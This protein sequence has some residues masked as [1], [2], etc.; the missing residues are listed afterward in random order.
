MLPPPISVSPERSRDPA[1]EYKRVTVAGVVKS[2]SSERPGLVTLEIGSGSRT[3]WAT[4]PAS[5]AVID[6]QWIDAEVRASGVLDEALDGSA[7]GADSRLWMDVANSLEIVHPATPL[8]ALPPAAIRTLLAV[9]PAKLPQHRVRVRGVPYMP[10]LGGIG[11]LD[12]RGQIQVRMVQ[13]DLDPNT[14]VLDVA[15]FLTWEQGHA[16]LDHAVPIL[17]PVV[18]EPDLAPVPGTLTTA[19]QVHSLSLIEAQRAYAVKL[20]AVVTF[21][22]PADHVLFVQDQSDGIFVQ[23]SVKEKAP[24][25]AGDL[26]E[27]TGVTSADFAPNIDKARVKIIGHPGLPAAKKGSYE[28]AGWGR[29]DCHWLELGGVVQG[30]A[31]GP[32]DALVTIASGRNM[33]KAHVLATPESLAHLVD[34]EVKVRG[35]LG[36]LFNN[37]HQLLGIQMF[38]P[39]A[40]FI[41]VTETPAADPFSVAPTSIADLLRFSKARDMGHRVRVRGTVTYPSQTGPTWVRDATGGVKIHDHGAEELATGDLVDVVGYSD[42]AGFGPALHG[43]RVKRLQSGKPPAPVRVTAQEAMKAGLD[44]QLVQIEGKLLDR[45]QQPGE[46]VLAVEAGDVIFNASLLGG[47]AALRLESGTRLRLTGICSV[48]TELSHDLILPR[49][50]RLLLRS[51]EDIVIVGRPPL[52]TVDR[53]LPILGG[54]ALL[55]LAALAWVGLLRRRVRTQ[56]FALRAQT[57]QLKAAHEKTIDALRKACEAES[58]DL[59]SKRILEQI[60]RDEPVDV[61]VDHIAEAAALHCED[62]VCAILLGES[63]GS[64]VCAVPPMPGSWMDML[65]KIEVSSV[66]FTPE[67]RA[68]SQLS[69][70]PAWAHFVDAQPN[71]RF[72]TVSSAPIV[73]DGATAGAIAAFFRKEKRRC[74]APGE[75]LGLWCNIAALALERRKLH[76]QLSHRA[77]HD[78]LTGL[79]NR[80]LLYENLAAEI[81]RASRDGDSFAVLY[82]DLDGFK[83]INDTYG[84]GAGDAVLRETANRL[85]DSVRRGE[86]VAR[87]GGDEFVVLLPL[88]GRRED[89]RQIAERIAT[90]LGKPI[91]SNDHRLTVSASIG[92]GIWPTDG[93]Q[94]DPLLRFADAQM[95]G[96]KRRRWYDSP[97]RRLPGLHPGRTENHLLEAADAQLEPASKESTG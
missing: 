66:L 47:A 63:H 5:N 10:R 3:V 57:V 28:S 13:V 90:E 71:A 23:L 73:V 16:L 19:L 1:Y 79:P 25:R 80:A 84:H 77:Q 97:V 15:G 70:D 41:R 83:Q 81:T 22:N 68:P 45:L 44:G 24:L 40:E 65:G 50:F 39:G 7:A 53:V 78:G 26:V 42:I 49:G 11:V 55:T 29:E 38:V 62:S 93:D 89:A 61:I 2:L 18:D 43:A 52:L 88:L 6:D 34:T 21:F 74:N 4:I 14:R 94:P 96:E 58:L 54:A 20:R 72:R 95:Y 31:K 46:Q 56:T 8:A 69:D 91:F 64:R 35:V 30:V 51:P 87:I 92:I 17:E 9:V 33:Y 85:T 82:I 59:D 76:D 12:E 48:E 32:A 86:M 67:F 37:N 27:V 60:A 75:Q 36:A